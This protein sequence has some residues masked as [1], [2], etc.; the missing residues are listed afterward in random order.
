MDY[1]ESSRRTIMLNGVLEIGFD[2]T[3]NSRREEPDEV[4]Q[5]PAAAIEE[6]IAQEQFNDDPFFPAEE[7]APLPPPVAPVAPVAEAPSQGVVLVTLPSDRFLFDTGMSHI[8]S[9]ES[10][11]YLREYGDVLAENQNQWGKLEISGHTDR[12]GTRKVNKELSEARARTIYDILANAGVP[13]T[14][15]TSKG[16]HFSKPVDKKNNPNAWAKNR[17]VEMRFTGVKATQQML[18]QIQELNRRYG[19][20]SGKGR[21]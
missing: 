4:E 2:L 8:R 21:Y 14:K 20:E 19:F 17:R 16:Y 12:R 1:N 7:P 11:A 6:P 18:D 5:V 10:R 13:R 15:M 9:K 3:R